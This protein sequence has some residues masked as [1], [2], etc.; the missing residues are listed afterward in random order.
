MVKGELHRPGYCGPSVLR[1]RLESQHRKIVRVEK[2]FGVAHAEGMVRLA[3]VSKAPRFKP[4]GIGLFSYR[5][6]C[7]P[8][9]RVFTAVLDRR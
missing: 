4:S 6:I 9:R 5:P 3:N 7:F 2:M 1:H 8:A